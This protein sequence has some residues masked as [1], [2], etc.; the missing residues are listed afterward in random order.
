VNS[1]EDERDIK[2]RFL[3]WELIVWDCEVCCLVIVFPEMD[4]ISHL[5]YVLLS[6]CHGELS[7]SG[8]RKSTLD[9]YLLDELGM[10]FLI[11]GMR[12]VP[13]RGFGS[14]V[15]CSWKLTSSGPFSKCHRVFIGTQNEIFTFWM[16]NIAAVVTDWTALCFDL[17][18]LTKAHSI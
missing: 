16:K 13:T 14:Q 9:L 1:G 10:F 12:H 8:M 18:N 7:G 4:Q 5:M 15:C 2:G 6:Q 17:F 3:P 11:L